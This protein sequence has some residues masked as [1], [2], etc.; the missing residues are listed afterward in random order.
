LVALS[1][2]FLSAD[3]PNEEV[4]FSKVSSHEARVQELEGDLSRKVVEAE[5]L[6]SDLKEFWNSMQHR[7]KKIQSLFG[8]VTSLEAEREDLVV[9]VCIV[10]VI[11][12]KYINPTEVVE[13]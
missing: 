1:G 12:E 2:S 4:S 13:L 5:T 8:H 7:D 11:V 10:Q 6:K 3:L 9:Q